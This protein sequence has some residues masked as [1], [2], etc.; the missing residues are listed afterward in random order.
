MLSAKL[1]AKHNFYIQVLLFS[2][3]TNAQE[4]TISNIEQTETWIYVYD[5]KGKK[6][7]TKSVSEAG[8]VIGWSAT[9]WISRHNGWYYLWNADGR[10]YKTLNVNNIG[11]II[12]VSGNTFTSNYKNLWIYTFDKNGKRINTRS[13]R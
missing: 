7:Y 12:A 3:A 5:Q 10:R 4:K 6:V 11:N 13:A 1:F 2:L 9:L 8:D